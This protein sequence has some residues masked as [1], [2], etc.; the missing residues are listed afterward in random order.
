MIQKI[1]N[2]KVIKMGK[3]KNIAIELE[4]A[5]KLKRHLDDLE[6]ELMGGYEKFKKAWVLDVSVETGHGF[7]HRYSQLKFPTPFLNVDG[8]EIKDPTKEVVISLGALWTFKDGVL[9]SCPIYK[10]NSIPTEQCLMSGHLMPEWGEI[11]NWEGVSI[12][13][14]HNMVTALKIDFQKHFEEITRIEDEIRFHENH[15]MA[16]EIEFLEKENEVSINRKEEIKLRSILRHLKRFNEI[17][18]EDHKLIKKAL[19]LFLGEY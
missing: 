11:E 16:H 19:S 4:E 6:K 12:A 15:G 1:K 9:W 10:D 3:F 18:P 7:G 8:M 14:L 5:E 13:L 2:R 17:N